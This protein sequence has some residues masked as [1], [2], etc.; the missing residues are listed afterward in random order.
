MLPCGG[1]VGEAA[2]RLGGL[3]SRKLASSA[4]SEQEEFRVW[5]SS[6]TLHFRARGLSLLPGS[7]SSDPSQNM[8]SGKD[9]LW[10]KA[11]GAGCPS[12]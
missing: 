7:S 8:N 1:A 12:L 6:L 10:G 11:A 3:G 9:R 2:G 4:D 5:W